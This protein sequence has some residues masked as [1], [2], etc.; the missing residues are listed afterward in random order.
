MAYS[1]KSLTPPLSVSTTT[2]SSQPVGQRPSVIALPTA[3][4]L[5]RCLTI[6]LKTL[7]LMF[8]AIRLFADAPAA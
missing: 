7:V 3:A 6:S 5:V 1:M 8:A 4:R 2:I